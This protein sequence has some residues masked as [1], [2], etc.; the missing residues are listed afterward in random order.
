MKILSLSLKYFKSIQ[1]LDVEFDRR[2]RINSIYGSNGSGKTTILE[3]FVFLNRLF[4]LPPN[5]ITNHFADVAFS[6]NDGGIPLYRSSARQLM[7]SYK[8]F[9]TIGF[10]EDLEVK[11]SFLIDDIE[12]IYSIV[13]N[14][15]NIIKRESLE[16]NKKILF[17][18]ERDASNHF[19]DDV[20]IFD[21]NEKLSELIGDKFNLESKGA[22]LFNT[23]SMVPILRIINEFK[24]LG[25]DMEI[26]NILSNAF[27]NRLENDK[28]NDYNISMFMSLFK[29][30]IEAMNIDN[31][32]DSIPFKTAERNS[33]NFFDFITKFDESIK[34]YDLTIAENNKRRKSRN[35]IVFDISDEIDLNKTFDVELHLIKIIG[36]KEVSIPYSLESEGTTKY[37]NLHLVYEKLISDNHQVAVMDEIGNSL[38]E[39]MLLNVYNNLLKVATENDKQLF[40]TSHNAILLASQF[41]EPIEDSKLWNKSKW[42]VIRDENGVT[43]M[44]D[45]KNKHY[46]ENNHIKF[47][48]GLYTNTKLNYPE[49]E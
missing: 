12:Y 23:I 10:D 30:S 14:R 33:K 18:V 20:I 37:K 35:G 36:G 15:D 39:T 6:E 38:N 45:L 34:G 5:A 3:S 13:M 1:K 49:K 2:V 25:D 40:V 7:I 46:K 8:R 42:I 31:A 22:S 17:K 28:G 43:T 11:I 41:I 24:Q 26:I 32:K 47:I 4:S 19:N 29:F 48:M 9:F 21:K 16:T 44:T 27:P